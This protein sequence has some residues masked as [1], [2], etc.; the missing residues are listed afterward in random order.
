MSRGGDGPRILNGTP[1]T[2]C[3]PVGFPHHVQLT[4]VKR[5]SDIF[6]G[7][8]LISARFMLQN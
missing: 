8:T 5:P 4:K 6:C 3:S 1:V 7:G 2:A